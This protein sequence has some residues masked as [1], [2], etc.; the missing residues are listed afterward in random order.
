MR[1]MQRLNSRDVFSPLLRQTKAVVFYSTPH[2]GSPLI[3]NH[4]ALLQSLFGFTPIM[5]E[6][7]GESPLLLSLNDSFL[8]LSPR[9]T[10]LSLGEETTLKTVNEHNVCKALQMRDRGQQYFLLLLTVIEHKDGVVQKMT[11][12]WTAVV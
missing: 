1:V 6:L 12:F 9:P 7:K 2:R 5:R 4:M 8:A 3:K 10:I 11:F